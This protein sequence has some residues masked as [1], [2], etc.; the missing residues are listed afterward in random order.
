M[1]FGNGCKVQIRGMRDQG[2]GNQKREGRISKS[3]DGVGGNLRSP[4]FLAVAPLHTYTGT[5]EI[6]VVYS[7]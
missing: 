7:E 3:V 1:A 5:C 4:F 6:D 2:R